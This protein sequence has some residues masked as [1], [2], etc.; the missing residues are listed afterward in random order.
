MGRVSKFLLSMGNSAGLRV[1]IVHNKQPWNCLADTFSEPGTIPSRMCPNQRYIILL[2]DVG[3]YAQEVD[4]V[5]NWVGGEGC[6]VARVGGGGV[7]EEVG[8]PR[9]L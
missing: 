9:V 3:F 4:W 7:E 6:V 8:C 5:L 1:P 2:K